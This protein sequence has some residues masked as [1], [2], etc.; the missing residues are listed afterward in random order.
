MPGITPLYNVKLQ[1]SL[2]LASRP[3]TATNPAKRFILK[4]IGAANKVID[5]TDMG[6]LLKFTGNRI[7]TLN[8]D[9]TGVINGDTFTATTDGTNISIDGTAISTV[10]SSFDS[11]YRNAIAQFI[12]VGSNI[13]IIINAN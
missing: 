6:R 3:L 1:S 8:S 4:D 12:Y 10:F 13:W 9:I 7:I 11:S 2:N 5:V